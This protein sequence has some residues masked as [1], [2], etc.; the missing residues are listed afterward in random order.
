MTDVRTINLDCLLDGVGRFSRKRSSHA[1]EAV[2]V[3]FDKLTDQSRITCRVEGIEESQFSIV[4]EWSE[5]LTKGDRDS[6][7]NKIDLAKWAGVGIALSMITQFSE[8]TVSEEAAINSGVDFYLGDKESVA[9]AGDDDFIER[10]ARLEA[11]GILCA[12]GGNTVARRRRCKV[13]QTKKSDCDGTPA[14]IIIGEFS[15]PLVDWTKR[16][17]TDE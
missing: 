13:K 10:T 12:K 11:S 14:F 16:Y 9:Q 1:Y 2:L 5:G 4:F 8:Y 6:W 15:I 17:P 3:C 7:K